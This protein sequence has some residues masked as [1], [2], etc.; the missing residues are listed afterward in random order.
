MKVKVSVAFKLS[1]CCPLPPE[2]GLA[3]LVV[4]AVLLAGEVITVSV[5]L[6][7]TSYDVLLSLYK[8]L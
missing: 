3:V 1:D 6:P 5:E 8:K 2:V 4:V 7:V